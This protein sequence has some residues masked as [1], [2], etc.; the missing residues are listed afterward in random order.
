MQKNLSKLVAHKI[1][2]FFSADEQAVA[3]NSIFE[4][5]DDSMDVDEDASRS[6][7]SSDAATT[8]ANDAVTWNILGDVP[9][10]IMMRAV[11][12][13]EIERAKGRG[14]GTGLKFYRIFCLCLIFDP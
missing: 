2:T 14:E 8:S 9:D 10:D 13:L 3:Q 6:V 5:E 7:F 4:P 1:Y 12:R 11:A